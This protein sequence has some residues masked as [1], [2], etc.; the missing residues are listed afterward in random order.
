MEQ[1]MGPC[2]AGRDGRYAHR[3]PSDIRLRWSS[4]SCTGGSEGRAS[5]EALL[6]LVRRSPVLTSHIGCELSDQARSGGDLRSSEPFHKETAQSGAGVD[7]VLWRS[8]HDIYPG[9]RSA[10]T[11]RDLLA[12]LFTG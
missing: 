2:T 11:S 7:A 12:L 3:G 8:Q 4:A 1:S 9:S 6:H 10:D 5:R